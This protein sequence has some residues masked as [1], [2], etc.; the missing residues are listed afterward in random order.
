MLTPSDPKCLR[1]DVLLGKRVDV[2]NMEEDWQEKL[3]NLTQPQNQPT[4]A[5]VMVASLDMIMPTVPKLLEKKGLEFKYAGNTHVR[6]NQELKTKELMGYGGAN[7]SMWTDNASYFARV[8]LQDSVFGKQALH[9]KSVCWMNP[10]TAIEHIPADWTSV[11]IAI[12][13]AYGRQFRMNNKLN[14]KLVP[15]SRI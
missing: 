14:V 6:R 15:Q 5:G 8:V 2:C 4:F 7:N 10:Y 1:F 3:V 13:H 12:Y 11:N 9:L